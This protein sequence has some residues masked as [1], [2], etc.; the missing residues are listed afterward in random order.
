VQPYDYQAYYSYES[1]GLAYSRGLEEYILTPRLTSD[2]Y[3]EGEMPRVIRVLHPNQ[4]HTETLVTPG[5]SSHGVFGLSMSHNAVGTKMISTAQLVDGTSAVLL[6]NKG[7]YRWEMETYFG[8]TLTTI[9][10][11]ENAISGD[12]NYAFVAIYDSSLST[13]IGVDVYIYAAGNWS[14]QTTLTPTSYAGKENF[15][16]VMA[17][18]ETGT[19]LFVGAPNISS[20][21]DSAVYVYTRSGSSWTQQTILNTPNGPF[22]NFGI[23]LSMSSTGDKCAVG[24]SVT[25]EVLLYSG[26]LASWSVAE[27]FTPALQPADTSSQFGAAVALSGDGNMLAIGVPEGY[28]L[29]TYN[30]W[31]WVEVFRYYSGSWRY[32]ES[33]LNQMDNSRA[34]RFGDAIAINHD[35][36][37]I[38]VGA[39]YANAGI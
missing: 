13:H 23:S 6:W 19:V 25:G 16:K 35:G 14:Y 10:Y 30:T 12:G 7:E 31:G 20:I 15:G 37:F 33:I 38:L 29:P 4:A 27:T 5:W 8:A 28:S 39:P 21:S 24:D 17:V 3:P 26:S 9:R 22:S 11:Q 32:E 1:F 34:G 2:A 36:S 18:N